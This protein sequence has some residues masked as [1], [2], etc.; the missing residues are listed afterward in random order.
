VNPRPA[1][2]PGRALVAQGLGRQ[3]VVVAT[4]CPALQWEVTEGDVDVLDLFDRF[5]NEPGLYLWAGTPK[6][7][8]VHGENYEPYVE[9]PGELRPVGP[10]EV[11]ELLALSCPEPVYADEPPCDLC[12]ESGFPGTTER[13]CP[14]CSPAPEPTV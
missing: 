14:K 2:P 12:N 1:F 13:N 5:K 6:W 4:D 9:F 8:G 7:A 11:A 3:A 10:S